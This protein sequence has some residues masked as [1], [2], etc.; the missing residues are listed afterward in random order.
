MTVR[1][2][3]FLFEPD[4]P[5]EIRV[6]SE[7]PG[8]FT[9]L[10]LLNDTTSFSLL[11]YAAEPD[12]ALTQFLQPTLPITNQN[13]SI[14]LLVE[15]FGNVFVNEFTI[16]WT[17]NGEDQTSFIVENANWTNGETTNDVNLHVEFETFNFDPAIDNSIVAW[18]TLP[19]G[20]TDIN[21]DNDQIDLF[22]SAV[23]ASY[24]QADSVI[25]IC[26]GNE[27]SFDYKDKVE[28]QTTCCECIKTLDNHEWQLNAIFSNETN[29]SFTPEE[30]TFLS[31]GANTYL[32]CEPKWW[33]FFLPYDCRN[34]PGPGGGVM[35]PIESD[36]IDYTYGIIVLDCPNYTSPP[37]VSMFNCE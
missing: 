24:Y 7:N 22:Y 31:F 37:S 10:N 19:D 18:V 8:G 11:A 23:N 6:W 20:Q 17:L 21:S 9:D 29:M 34:P 13:A 30:S 36:I 16:N 25:T 5:N 15:S 32:S 1:F 14:E 35:C 28:T 2:N 33:P 27:I 12:L 26:R 4:R 3:S